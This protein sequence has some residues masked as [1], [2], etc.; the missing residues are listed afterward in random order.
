[1]TRQGSLKISNWPLYIDNA[2]IDEFDKETGIS[3]N[4]TEDVNDNT[5]F[6]GKMQPLLEPG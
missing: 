3:T 4:Y 2:T 5:D 1:M 6:F